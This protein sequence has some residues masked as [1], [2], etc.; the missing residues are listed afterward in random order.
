M[1][2]VIAV[3]LA[4]STAAERKR[5]SDFDWECAH[6]MDHAGC[7]RGWTTIADDGTV[8]KTGPADGECPYLTQ[9]APDASP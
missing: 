9:G 6:V 1:G 4:E 8:Y 3:R 5:C 2:A 7:H